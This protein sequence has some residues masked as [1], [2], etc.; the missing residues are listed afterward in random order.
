MTTLLHPSNLIQTIFEG[1]DKTQ[2]CVIYMGIGTHYY[3]LSGWI[4]EINQQ[5]PVFLH[6]WKIN[7]PDIPIKIILFDQCTKSVP[8]I[9]TDPSSFFAG[10][11]VKNERYSNV[12]TS[13]FGIE[14]Y[15]FPMNVNWFNDCFNTDGYYDITGLIIDIVKFVSDA[16]YL[17]FFHEF[18]G[19]NP[20]NLEYEIKKLINFD[21]NKVCIDI[22]RGRDL[23]CRVDFSEPENYPLIDLNNK[24]ISWINPKF[25]KLDK[26]QELI[27]K[28]TNKEITTIECPY[29]SK[30]IFDYYLFK[31]I[32]NN[33]QYIY[34]ICKKIIYVM[35][36]LYN[37]DSEFS[38]WA[39]ISI[40]KL[41]ILN[42]KIPNIEI[43]ISKLFAGII[44]IKDVVEHGL[45]KEII[46]P[47]K[48]AVLEDLKSL[49]EICL[50]NI[51]PL[52]ED[53][54]S[55]LFI[56][57]DTSDDKCNLITIFNDFCSTHNI[58][59]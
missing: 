5:F 17:F 33:N 32:I 29:Y 23:S 18:T 30:N 39:E 34:N 2:P 35:R 43:I 55:V 1:K 45:A 28:F 11:F 51:K 22:T 15:S 59:F 38:K 42:I 4:H 20:E 25:I 37:K 26:R 3:N 8:Y 21:E 13:E 9:I 48:I 57:F 41:N 24:N 16:N 10:S 52:P 36:S 19:R 6:D 44:Q 47:Y 27:D 53:E 56:M 7:N 46:Y 31:H 58:C 54:L 40:G 50:S 12:Y 14:V 49:I